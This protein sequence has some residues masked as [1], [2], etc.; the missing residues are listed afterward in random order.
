MVTG[1]NRIGTLPRYAPSSYYGGSRATAVAS[2]GRGCPGRAQERRGRTREAPG[3]AR[4]DSIRRVVRTLCVGRRNQGTRRSPGGPSR[5]W[6]TATALVRWSAVPAVVETWDPH[7]AHPAQ[8]ASRQ[9]PG[10]GVSAAREAEAVSS[11]PAGDTRPDTPIGPPRWQ[12]AAG[13]A[14]RRCHPSGVRGKLGRG[15]DRHD[16]L[17]RPETTGQAHSG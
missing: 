1:G 16:I 15:T 2:R 7:E 17:R 5:Q 6:R 13:V 10:P 14:K 11:G 12:T 8:W 3:S 9:R 4:D